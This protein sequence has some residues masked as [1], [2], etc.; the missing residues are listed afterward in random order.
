MHFETHSAMP[1]VWPCSTQVLY[2]LQAVGPSCIRPT[3]RHNGSVFGWA[4]QYE[5]GTGCKTIYGTATNVYWCRIFP[6]LAMTQFHFS[7]LDLM[8]MIPLKINLG[9][10]EV[11]WNLTH[12]PAAPEAVGIFMLSGVALGKFI[13]KALFWDFEGEVPSMVK[14]MMSRCIPPGIFSILMLFMEG[15]FGEAI[16]GSNHL[17]LGVVRV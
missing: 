8:K 7:P 4:N 9:D 10:R 14:D 17:S 2:A 16:V 12:L 6:S 5:S 15:C 1:S 13:L 11:C 3:E